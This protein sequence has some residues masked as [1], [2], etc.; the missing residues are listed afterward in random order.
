MIIIRYIRLLW[1]RLGLPVPLVTDYYQF[2]RA[3]CEH[4]GGDVVVVRVGK[5]RC[6]ECDQ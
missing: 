3:W 1:M 4:C 2:V 5:F 6:L